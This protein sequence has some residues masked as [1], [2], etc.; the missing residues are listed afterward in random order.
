MNHEQLKKI[1]KESSLTQEQKDLWESFINNVT[2]KEI[3]AI[4]EVLEE[5]PEQLD[6][7]TRN[8]ESKTELFKTKDKELL[9]KILTEEKN[10]LEE[11]S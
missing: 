4:L 5:S 3:T 10:Y 8:L 11:Q 2:E 7:L 6:F 1:I 9:E